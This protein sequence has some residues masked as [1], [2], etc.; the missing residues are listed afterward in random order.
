MTSEEKNRL[1]AELEDRSE[2]MLGEFVNLYVHATTCLEKTN[3]TV[4]QIRSFFEGFR[5][6]ELVDSIN[7]TD[8]IAEIIRK[9]TRGNYW[10][11]F[12]FKLLE[13]MINTFCKDEAVYTELQIYVSDFQNFC[14]NRVYEVPADLIKCAT[15]SSVNPKSLLTVKLDDTFKITLGELHK[16]RNRIEKLLNI[17]YLYLIDIKQGCIELIL[18]HHMEFGKIFPLH[19]NQI[20]GL[21]KIGVEWLQCDTYKIQITQGKDQST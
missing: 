5:L 1:I 3:V 4:D 6:T 13:N 10:S 12:N 21:K 14:R 9:V 2:T 18:R 17:E 20:A 15:N 16:I 11:F 8:S 19:R 7:A